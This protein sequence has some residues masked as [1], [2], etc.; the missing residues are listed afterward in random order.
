[1]KTYARRHLLLLSQEIADAGAELAMLRE[2]LLADSSLLDDL[3][4]RMLIAET[5]L[6]DRDLHTAALGV[7]RVRRRI[8]RLESDLRELR[9]EERR[10]ERTS[11]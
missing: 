11:T 2:R 10:L 6:A 4:L 7:E 5:P 3:R 1:M 9:A 8:A